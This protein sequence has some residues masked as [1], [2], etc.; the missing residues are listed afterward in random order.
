VWD[1]EIIS[2][3][4]GMC[5]PWYSTHGVGTTSIMLATN[6]L[7]L[8]ANVTWVLTCR[9]MIWFWPD[10]DLLWGFHIFRSRPS[11]R[12][13]VCVEGHA[14]G[15]L[16][17]GLPFLPLAALLGPPHTPC[18]TCSSRPTTTQRT[19]PELLCIPNTRPVHS[20]QAWPL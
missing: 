14:R 11:G 6:Q 2:S 20:I 8:V 10:D 17:D 3:R 9:C 7:R 16:G 18:H 4:S 1:D 5:W 13:Q 19:Q 12:V 15:T